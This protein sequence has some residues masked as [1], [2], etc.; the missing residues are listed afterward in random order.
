MIFKIKPG[1]YNKDNVKYQD[2]LIYNKKNN[3]L[4]AL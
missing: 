4:F 1:T 2:S 3:K